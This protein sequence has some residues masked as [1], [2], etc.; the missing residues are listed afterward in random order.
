[1]RVRNHRL[2]PPSGHKRH[3]PQLTGSVTRTTQSGTI[4]AGTIQAGTIQAGTI[5]SG[6]IQSGTAAV[7]S[8]AARGLNDTRTR[9]AASRAGWP[10]R[11]S[12]EASDDRLSG[13]PTRRA[14]EVTGA[15]R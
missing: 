13:S 1:M 14:P 8:L 3:H 10:L 11:Q 6:T 5:Q 7:T 2:P 15:S 9:A 4:Q 12:N